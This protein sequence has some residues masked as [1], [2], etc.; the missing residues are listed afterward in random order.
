MGLG[1]ATFNSLE[2][3]ELS[4]APGLPD[5]SRGLPTSFQASW[6]GGLP[7]SFEQGASPLQCSP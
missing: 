1:N 3:V 5:A 7:G 6:P 4:W 2:G